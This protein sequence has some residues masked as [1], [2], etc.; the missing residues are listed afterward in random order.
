M[1]VSFRTLPLQDPVLPPGRPV[2]LSALPCLAFLAG[3]L[4][5]PLFTI[6]YLGD[7]LC[8]QGKEYICQRGGLA[9]SMS[10]NLQR[11]RQMAQE[12]RELDRDIGSIRL[13]RT[14]ISWSLVQSTHDP[15]AHPS[16]EYGGVRPG[17]GP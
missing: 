6:F 13:H 8:C 12:K 4:T 7:N 11:R 14:I 16:T 10:G 15:S 17:G 9:R 2:A 5:I 1:D 3:Q